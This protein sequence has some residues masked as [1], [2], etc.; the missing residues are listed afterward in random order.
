MKKIPSDG[1]FLNLELLYFL[2]SC[3]FL[4]HIKAIV[5][6]FSSINFSRFHEVYIIIQLITIQIIHEANM[7]QS[8]ASVDLPS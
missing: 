8:K 1:R 2:W 7:F 5:I 6:L 3:T 4:R